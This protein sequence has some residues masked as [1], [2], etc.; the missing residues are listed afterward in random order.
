MLGTVLGQVGFVPSSSE[1]KAGRGGRGQAGSGTERGAAGPGGPRTAGERS[2][3]QPGLQRRLPGGRRG[4]GGGSGRRRRAEEGGALRGY[5]WFALIPRGNL[6]LSHSWHSSR[7]R[8]G[9]TL[10]L[11]AGALAAR[12]SA[13]PPRAHLRCGAEPSRARLGHQV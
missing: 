10:G 12:A 5:L 3:G 4:P 11:R 9:L 7:L 1:G 8:R 2:W 6:K 13:P